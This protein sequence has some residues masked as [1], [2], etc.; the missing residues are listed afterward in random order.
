[1]A[2]MNDI[3]FNVGMSVCEDTM[4]RCCLLLGMYLTDNPELE[5]VSRESITR[6]GERFVSVFTTR[7]AESEVKPNE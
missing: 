4:N 2:K 3:T 7:K 1:M 5:L 6:D